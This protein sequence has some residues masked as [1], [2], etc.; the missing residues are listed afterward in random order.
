MTSG[1]V[2]LAVLVALA[3]ASWILQA[4][5]S[6]P[7]RAADST[8]LHDEWIRV[9]SPNLIVLTN[10]SAPDAIATARGIERLREAYPAMTAE[11]KR[12]SV[13][14]T[15]VLLFRD[16]KS[17]NAYRERYRGAVRQDAGMFVRT[18][19]ASYLVIDGSASIAVALHEYT[20]LLV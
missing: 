18:P 12:E 13:L 19:F 9:Q 15:I 14:P 5:A 20:H 16:T 10:G 7:A 17:F 1:R 2:S 8:P 11:L 3:G 4:L 6:P